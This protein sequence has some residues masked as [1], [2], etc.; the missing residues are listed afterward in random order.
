MYSVHLICHLIFR[1]PMYNNNM[2]INS[3]LD[4]VFNQVQYYF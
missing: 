4:R 1:E 2:I 3:V